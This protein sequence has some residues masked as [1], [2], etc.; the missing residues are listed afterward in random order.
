MGA[1]DIALTV[2]RSI[3]S[4]PLGEIDIVVLPTAFMTITFFE[5]D[6]GGAAH[7]VRISNAAVTGFDFGIVAAG[8]F[9]DGISRALSNYLTT[10]LGVLFI[11]NA[12]TLNQRKTALVQRL[13]TDGVIT[14]TFTVG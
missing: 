1:G 7:V 9:T 6:A 13:V 8:A 11:G 10:I 14:G 12:T 4:L 5:V 3:P 2:P